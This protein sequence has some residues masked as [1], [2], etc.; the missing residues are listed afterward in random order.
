M[1][2]TSAPTAATVEEGPKAHFMSLPREVRDRIYE[3]VVVAS[4]PIR[5]DPFYGPLAQ[6]VEGLN[7]L[8]GWDTLRQI[9]QE[10]C[11]IFYQRNIF[12]VSCPDLSLLL[13]A[14]MQQWALHEYPDFSDW[15]RDSLPGP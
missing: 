3:Q 7:L 5:F 1:A 2:L 10:A 8:Y 4:Q 14:N 15:S 13:S 9:T 6:M 12:E 11:E